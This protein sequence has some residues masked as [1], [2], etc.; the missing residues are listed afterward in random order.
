MMIQNARFYAVVCIR[1]AESAGMSQLQSDKKSVLRTRGALMFF[2]KNV[3]QFGQA[4]ARVVS[5]HKLIR[6]SASF[7]RNR[8]RLP[9]PDEFRSTLSKSPPPANRMLARSSIRVA[10]PPFHWLNSDAVSDADSSA[11]QRQQQRGFRSMND[12]RVT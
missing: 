8:N 2:D 11:H 5:H 3:S 7:M 10:I 12:F 9:S 4:H 1:L 6:I